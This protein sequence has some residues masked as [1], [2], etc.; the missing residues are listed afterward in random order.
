[1]KPNDG[2]LLSRFA[3]IIILRRYREVDADDGSSG[4]TDENSDPG[5]AVHLRS[6]GS[7]LGTAEALQ[8]ARARQAELHGRD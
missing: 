8:T 5:T 4:G 1:L 6:S 3:F 7:R 2:R